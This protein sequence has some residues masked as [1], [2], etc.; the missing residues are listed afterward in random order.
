[1]LYQLLGDSN[2]TE[3]T[4]INGVGR[5]CNGNRHSIMGVC[6]VD[7]HSAVVREDSEL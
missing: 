5:W 2:Y 7:Y 1:M 6:G 3:I 4:T